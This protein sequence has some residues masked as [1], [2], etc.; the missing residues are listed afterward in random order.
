[1]NKKLDNYPFSGFDYTEL[2]EAWNIPSYTYSIYNDIK[3]LE[4]FLKE[5][6][7]KA[8]GKTDNNFVIRKVSKDIRLYLKKM[9]E[10]SD[11]SY[12]NPIWKGLIKVESDITLIILVID[13]LKHM[14]N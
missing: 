11:S 9:L 3:P 6:K 7:Y 2:S 14:W 13:L 10:Y 8:F 1:M 5:I 12:Y 4:C